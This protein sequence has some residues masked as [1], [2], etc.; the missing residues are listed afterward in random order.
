MGISRV[1]DFEE[2]SQA[3]KKKKKCLDAAK[4]AKLRTRRN[5]AHPE[6]DFNSLL[7]GS[8]VYSAK[9]TTPK[10]LA[11]VLLFIWQQS[12]NILQL[13]YLSLLAM[14]LGTT[15]TRIIPRH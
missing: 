10:E 14:L 9:A 4:E 1:R 15:K 6:L 13:K 3:P 7:E 8:I 12:W 2:D 5:H 11:L